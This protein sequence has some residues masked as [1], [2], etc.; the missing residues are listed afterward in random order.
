MILDCL[1]SSGMAKRDEFVELRCGK[2]KRASDA[3]PAVLWLFELVNGG[4]RNHRVLQRC[5]IKKFNAF[6]CKEI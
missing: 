4:R 1:E 3:R 5:F 2:V 6:I